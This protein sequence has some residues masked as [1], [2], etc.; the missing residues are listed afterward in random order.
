[1]P[2]TT[3]G[4]ALV[5]VDKA[6]GAARIHRPVVTDQSIVTLTYADGLIVGGTSIHGGY[7]VPT[8]TQTEGALFGF[9][10]TADTKV[11]E[12]V[13]VPGADQ[14]DGVVTDADGGVWGLAGGQLFAFDVASRAVTRRVTLPAKGGRL[15]YHA[16]SDVFYLLVAGALLRVSRGDLA[17]STVLRQPAQFLAVHPDGRVFLGD[18]PRVHRVNVS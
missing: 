17:V 13:P 6:T 12:T 14:V 1:M 10:P 11:F 8:P 9:D 4:G 5:I 2:N 15:A 7:S 18:G 16:G 3:L